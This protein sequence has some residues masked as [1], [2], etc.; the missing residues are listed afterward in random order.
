[1]HKEPRSHCPGDVG[2]VLLGLHAQYGDAGRTPLEFGFGLK[3][4]VAVGGRREEG[5]CTEEVVEGHVAKL[6]LLVRETNIAMVSGASGR[7]GGVG[8]GSDARG[9]TSG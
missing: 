2:R 1:M 5:V 4:V 9:G 3:G 6:V 8:V 7:T